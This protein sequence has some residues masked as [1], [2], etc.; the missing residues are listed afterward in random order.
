M[1]RLTIFWFALLVISCSTDDEPTI[2]GEGSTDSFDRTAMLEHWADNIIIPAYQAYAADLGELQTVVS[3]FTIA[4]DEAGLLTVRSAWL[5]AYRSWQSVATFEVGPAEAVRLRSFTNIYPT[6]ADAIEA[7]IR[8]K[9]FTLNLPSKIDQQ[10]LP[11]LDYLL[12]GLGD[13]EAEVVSVYANEPAYR[14]YLTAVTDQL[15]DLTDQVLSEWTESYRDIFVSNDGSSATGTI[16]KLAND[17]LFHY[18][19]DLRAAKVGIP[20]GVFSSTPLP[21]TVEGY[22]AG[23]ISGA[24]LVAALDAAQDFFNGRAVGRDT[25]GPGFRAY[26]NYLDNTEASEGLGVQIDQQFDE[27]RARA[28]QLE[29]NLAEQ[30]ATDNQAMLATYDALQKNVVLMKVDMFQTLNI[31]VDFVDAD[32]D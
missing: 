24:L 5:D 11:A 3:A 26:L 17:Y 28:T 27:A 8:D 14:D 12:Y 22:Y 32:G 6:D 1:K 19:K 2:E 4:P 10:G 9:N 16:N 25:E 13:T 18:E 20:A 23:D 21:E 15:V 7:N 30:I 31:K 29:D